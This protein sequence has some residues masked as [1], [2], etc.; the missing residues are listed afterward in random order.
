MCSLVNSAKHL[1]NISYQFFPTSFQR[2][3]QEE[4]ILT[5]SETRPT[6]VSKPDQ[7]TTENYIPISP[8]MDAKI[9]NKITAETKY[10]GKKLYPKWDLFQAC[11][12]MSTDIYDKTHSELTNL[13]LWLDQHLTLGL[14]A[15]GKVNQYT[16]NRFIL[17]LSLLPLSYSHLLSAFQV[18]VKNKQKTPLQESI[19]NYKV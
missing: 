7:H 18:A 19:G 12:I 11:T 4:Y 17:P 6:L 15:F 2:Q 9:L 13:Q 8:N 1:R 5:H 3:K 16:E 14:A 10:V